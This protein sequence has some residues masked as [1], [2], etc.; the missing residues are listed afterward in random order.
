MLDL[1]IHQNSKKQETEMQQMT[2]EQKKSQIIVSAFEEL[3]QSITNVNSVIEYRRKLTQINQSIR[4]EPTEGHNNHKMHIPCFDEELMNEKQGNGA[5]AIQIQMTDRTHSKQAPPSKKEIIQ[6]EIMKRDEHKVDLEILVK[7]YGTSIQKG[8]EQSRAEQLNLELGDNKLSEKPKEPLIFKFLRELVTPF[9]LLLWASA[10][11][12]FIAYDMKTSQPDNLYFGIILI[13]VV[14]IT[15]IITYQQNKKSEAIMDSFKNFLPQ[16]S[17]VIRNGYETQINAEKLVLGDIV[18]VKAGEKIPADIRLIQVNEM[19]VD[20]SALT[21]ESEPQIRSTICSHPESLLE[22]ANVAFFGTLC[23][24]GQGTGI[25]IQI[26]DKTTLGEIAGMAQAEKKTKTPLRIELDRLILFMVF[27]ALSLGVLFFLLSFFHAG[28]DAMTSVVYGIGILVVNVPEGLICCITISLAI[29]AQS[30]HKKNVLVKNL[31]SVETLG[32]TSCICSD[33]TGTLTQNVMTVEH[34]WIS[35]QQLKAKNKK[36]VEN[37]NELDYNENDAAFKELHLNAILSSDA[38]FDISQ[39]EDKQNIDYLK[40][41]VNGDATETG[42]VR[43]FQSIEDINVTRDKY[44]IPEN[45]EKTLARMP[46]NSTEKFALTIVEYKTETSDYCVYVKGAPEKI[47]KFCSHVLEGEQTVPITQE[48]EKKFQQINKT[49]GKKGER[50]LGFAKLHLPRQDYPLNNSN[51]Q[52]QSPKTFNFPINNYVFTGLISLI[53]PPKT[54][55]PGAILECR[56]AG[57]KVIMVTGDQPPTAASIAKQVNI[58]PNYV[59]TTEEMMDRL[60]IPW[61]EAVEK[62]EAIVIHGEKIVQSITLEEQ[63]GIEKFTNLRKWVKKPYCVFARTTPAQKLQIVQACQQEGYICAVTGDGV[64][65]SPAIKQGDIGISMNLTGSD[66]TKDAA[67]MILLDDDFASIV[68]GV[69]EGRKIFDNLKK[70]FVYLLCSNIPEILPF[71]AFIIFSIPLPLSNIYMLCI[72]VGTDIYPALSL[73]YEEAEIDIMTRRPREKN[74]HLI[75]LKLMA[76]SYGLMGIMSMSCGFLAYFTSLNYFGFKTLELFGMAT[77][78]AYKPP[79]NLFTVDPKIDQFSQ[80]KDNEIM[81]N[82]NVMLGSDTCEEDLDKLKQSGQDFSWTV[83]WALIGDGKYDLRKAF[84]ECKDHKWQSKVDGW[85]DCDINSSYT[86]SDFTNN[87]ACYSTDALKFAQSSFFCC[88]VIFQ[89]SNIFA[90]KARKS[91]FCT[92]PFNMKMIQGIIFETALAAFLVLTPGVNTVFGGRPIDFWQFGVSGV[93]FSIM[94]L[95]W[96]EIRKYLIR[97]HRWFL[98]YSYW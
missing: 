73:G 6:N 85:S 43:F 97:S 93:P 68:S 58:I 17:V 77:Y 82:S 13:A 27:V 1:N 67:D 33:K 65:D 54:R 35:G 34:I 91:S 28:Y 96:N 22:T 21:G 70:T 57:I 44:K 25:V 37:A 76:H 50:V 11:I 10:I 24:E 5:D 48:W 42:L 49:F 69:E 16:K 41:H 32:S 63:Q 84:I 64:N 95:A 53:D 79:I 40:C 90:C 89:W 87:T 3:R 81:F 74:D 92:S 47:W 88:I 71:L 19:K 38:K 26:G 59:E 36:L 52:V 80:Y 86:Y 20:N 51:F 7:R 18:K 9:A 4:L 61:E 15:A 83:D 94:V 8:H 45:D 75:S 23:K 55:V 12:C 30:L 60:N 39:L 14:L 78:T 72:C 31:E 62:C 46:F 66:V 98:K 29:T 56:S 2:K